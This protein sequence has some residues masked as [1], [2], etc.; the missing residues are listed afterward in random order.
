MSSGSFPSGRTGWAF[1]VAAVIARRYPDHK[2]VRFLA[3]GLAMADLASR[4]TSSNHFLGDAVF[5]A[6]LGYATGRFVI[7]RQ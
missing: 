5:G 3:Y 2:W 6:A 1:A 4:V 7:L